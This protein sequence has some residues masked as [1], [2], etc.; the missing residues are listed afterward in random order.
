MLGAVVSAGRLGTRTGGNLFDDAYKNCPVKPRL[1][2]GRI[3]DLTVA[4]ASDDED[5]GNVSRAATE[6]STWGLE[7]HAYSASPVVIRDDGDVLDA[8]TLSPDARQTAFTKVRTGT[9][10]TVQMVLA[11]DRADDNCL[12]GD[13]LE[14]SISQSLAESAFMAN[15][16]VTRLER[17]ERSRVQAEPPG[18]LHW[19]TG[20]LPSRIWELLTA[21]EPRGCVPEVQVPRPLDALCPQTSVF[22]DFVEA[23]DGD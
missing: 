2:D 22:S 19:G 15:V 8:K 20:H 18:N 9:A 6:P 4:R 5:K 7:P 21:V 12:I 11:V 16:H 14:K 13:I 17:A 23:V 10:V 3:S 1:R